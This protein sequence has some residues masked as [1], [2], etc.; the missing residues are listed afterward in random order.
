[1]LAY[2]HLQAMR[3]AARRSLTAA[4]FVGGALLVAPVVVAEP[5]DSDRASA[6]ELAREGYDA[7]EQKNYAV[8]ED[9]FRSKFS[10]SRP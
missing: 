1:M 4:A 6:R 2:I 7:L 8:A 10:L 3:R 5:T 9:R